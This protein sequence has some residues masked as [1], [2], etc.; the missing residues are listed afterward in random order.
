M[1]VWDG[2]GFSQWLSK[3]MW[4]LRTRIGA[5]RDKGHTHIQLDPFASL[6]KMVG[7]QPF[8]LFCLPFDFDQSL[9]LSSL[10]VG[11]CFQIE[12]GDA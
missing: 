9:C 3:A 2:R 1:T 11:P 10:V 12:S 8:L 5:V 7:F 6:T 4:P